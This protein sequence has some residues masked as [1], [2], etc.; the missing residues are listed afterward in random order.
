MA[1]IDFAVLSG[2]VLIPWQPVVAQKPTATATIVVRDENMVSAPPRPSRPVPIPQQARTAPENVTD[3]LP[4]C[5]T[6]F[7]AN[8]TWQVR[9]TRRHCTERGPRL[10]GQRS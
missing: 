4:E 8:V 6:N 5:L 10:G 3:R 1:R 9:L 7:L 2:R